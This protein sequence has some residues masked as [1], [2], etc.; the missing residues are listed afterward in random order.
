M[1]LFKGNHTGG[2]A[3]SFFSLGVALVLMLVSCSKPEVRLQRF[4]QDLFDSSAGLNE[5]HFNKL[6]QK[7]GVFYESFSKDLI[8]IPEEEAQVNFVPGLISFIRYPTIQKLKHELDSVYPNLD[9]LKTELQD[10]MAQYQDEFPDERIPEF[11]TFLS[12][13]G[14][15]HVS[16]DTLIGIGL[17]MYMGA[18]YPI[19]PALEFPEFMTKKLRREYIVPNTMKSLAISKYENQLRDKRFV[20]MLIFEGKLRYFMKAMLPNAH[21]SLILGYSAEQLKWAEEN[22]SMIWGHIIDS[23]L[24]YSK[25]VSRYMRYFD[26]GPFTSAP[27]VP[28]ESSPAIGV[29]AGY[30]LVQQLM[31]AENLSL[32]ELMNSN[33][34]DELLKRSKY[35]P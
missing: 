19:Y 28:A 3:R 7:Y 5:G 1:N 17:D 2:I 33:N 9:F 27:G 8:N 18:D 24:L 21:D 31:E 6:E 30:K 32:K 29:F 23:K 16:Y 14:Y 35:R 26:D 12:E 25:D 13:F 34:W 22:E 11:V 4:E 15:A 10:A 20:A